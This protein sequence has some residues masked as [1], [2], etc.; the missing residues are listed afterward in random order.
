MRLWLGAQVIC[1]EASLHVVSLLIFRTAGHSPVIVRCWSD[2]R[3]PKEAHALL[4]VG[5]HARLRLY[6]LLLYAVCCPKVAKTCCSHWEDGA[7]AA[8]AGGDS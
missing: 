6:P 7:D 3:Q 2:A 1:W 5:C 8:L 4:K